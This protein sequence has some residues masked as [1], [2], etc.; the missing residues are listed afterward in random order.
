M[1]KY[2]GSRG[3]GG[4][5]VTV[6]YEDGD[7]YPLPPRLDIVNHSPTGLNWGYGGSGPA[8]LAVALLADATGNDD[9]ARY[10]Y[11]EY[12]WDVVA[13]LPWTWELT[14]ESILDFLNKFMWLKEGA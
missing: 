6:R 5:A 4:S 11:Q 13:N 12:K 14:E 3:Y 1:K 2:I 9:I 7:E 8:Q 10:L